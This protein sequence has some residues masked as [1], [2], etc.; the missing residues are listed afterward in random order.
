MLLGSVV[1]FPWLMVSLLV[2]V[3]Q[4]PVVMR[5]DLAA[6]VAAVIAAV[7]IVAAIVV[8]AAAAAVIVVVIAVV[9]VVAVGSY[10]DSSLTSVLVDP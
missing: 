10:R 3:R 2:E 1:K 8:V 7:V 9:V 6:V 5:M 4:Q